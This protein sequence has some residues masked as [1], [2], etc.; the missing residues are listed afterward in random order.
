MVVSNIFCFYPY[1]GKIPMLNNIFQ[2]GWNHQ[3]VSLDNALFK[4]LFLKEVTLGGVWLVDQSWNFMVGTPKSWRFGWKHDFSFQLGDFV[5]CML[6]FRA[7]MYL[8]TDLLYLHWWCHGGNAEGF[9]KNC[10]L[11][12][13]FWKVKILQGSLNGT[14]LRGIKQAANLW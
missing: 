2:M 13:H 8:V 5:V 1:L 3:L 11:G 10:H 4:P 6:I 9:F 12:W 14:H 7:V